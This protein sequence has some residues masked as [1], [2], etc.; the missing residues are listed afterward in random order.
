VRAVDSRSQVHAA[1]SKSQASKKRGGRVISLVEYETR[2]VSFMY[3]MEE[4]YA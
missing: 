4:N 3:V 2:E 1:L